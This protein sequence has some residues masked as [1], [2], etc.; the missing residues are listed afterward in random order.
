ML[1]G[2]AA[3]AIAS[4][5]GN[6][7]ELALIRMQADATLPLEQ[8]RHYKGVIDATLRVIKEEGV[9]ELWRGSTP[10]VARAM[11]LNMSM[12]ATADQMK[13]VHIHTT[14]AESCT[15]CSTRNL[16]CRRLPRS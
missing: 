6:P 13:E 7:T 5:I 1:A 8:R 4:F 3:G 15:C 14:F 11:A 16:A 12:L 9:A 10:T 2:L